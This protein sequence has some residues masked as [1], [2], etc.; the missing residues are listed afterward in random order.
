LA[1]SIILRVPG[2]INL[3]GED[4]K[5]KHMISKGS[6]QCRPSLECLHMKTI[7]IIGGLAWPS[8]AVYYRKINEAIARQLGGLHCAR[9]VLVQTDFDLI[10]QYEQEGRWTLLGDEL[11]KLGNALKRA[12]ADF[13]LIACNTVH[14]AADQISSIV[15]LPFIHIVDPTGRCVSARGFK[16]VGLL[17]SRYTMREGFFVNRLEKGYGLRVLVAEGIHEDNIHNTLYKELAKGILTGAARGKFRDAMA[18]L[19]ARGAEAIILGCTEFGTLVREEDSPV[20]LVDTT[21]L[22]VEAA[23]DAALSGEDDDFGTRFDKD[24]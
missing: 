16:T 17:G 20:P 9:L 14:A 6:F 5:N 2:W 3:E 24:V 18:D 19:A 13:F 11:G 7:G 8:T 4:A 22:H 23:V 15:Q 10:E 1:E 21:I 12:G